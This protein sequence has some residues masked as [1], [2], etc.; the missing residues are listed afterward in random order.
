MF[1]C[2]YKRGKKYYFQAVKKITESFTVVN[3]N[4]EAVKLGYKQKVASFAFNGWDDFKKIKQYLRL[5][6]RLRIFVAQ[7]EAADKTFEKVIIELMKNPF[8]S[9]VIAE[10]EEQNEVAE[11]DT[12]NVR[13]Y[14][15]NDFGDWMAAQKE[16]EFESDFYKNIL[17]A[18]ELPN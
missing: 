12:G 18:E 16:F 6:F 15:I 7:V 8:Y 13:L 9:L 2:I 10:K 11:D 14:E 4:M 17:T 1:L 5:N 3:E